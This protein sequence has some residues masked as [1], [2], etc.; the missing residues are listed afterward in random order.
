MENN[1]LP[2]R[3]DVDSLQEVQKGS[4]ITI[5]HFLREIIGKYGKECKEVLR[6]IGPIKKSSWHSTSITIGGMLML[7]CTGPQ[8]PLKTA[9]PPPSSPDKCPLLQGKGGIQ[10]QENQTKINSIKVCKD[11]SYTVCTTRPQGNPDILGSFDP[12]FLVVSDLKSTEND[13]ITI[14]ATGEVQPRPDCFRFVSETNGQFY[15][16]VQGGPNNGQPSKTNIWAIAAPQKH[17]PEGFK[18][19]GLAWLSNECTQVTEVGGNF[20]DPWGNRGKRGKKKRTHVPFYNESDVSYRDYV[21]TAVDIECNPG[22]PVYAPCTGIITKSGSAGKEWGGYINLQCERN[23]D[24]LTINITHLNESSIKPVDTKIKE[25]DFIGTVFA[26]D[27]ELV[28]DEPNHFHLAICT[29]TDANCTATGFG[30][31]RGACR[32]TEWPGGLLPKNPGGQL[33]NPD[34]N[35]NTL[36]YPKFKK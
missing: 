3:I 10:V 13:N 7:A 8:E 11:F 1:I 35:T 18:K 21:H 2:Q 9:A 17:V 34:P 22:T 5:S 12:L 25:G 33:I 16:G 26:I 29:D 30:V 28:H 15:I 24:T 36:L 6:Q 23:G 19:E 27:Q 31:E 14:L 4:T 20:G 32:R